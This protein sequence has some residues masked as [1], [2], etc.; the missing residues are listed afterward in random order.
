ME[1][2]TVMLLKTIT[3]NLHGPYQATCEELKAID[4][5]LQA[6]DLAEVVE[7]LLQKKMN[8]NPTTCEV[9]VTTHND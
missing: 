9:L 6:M 1:N 2:A 8:D 7:K 4:D 3:I 5:T